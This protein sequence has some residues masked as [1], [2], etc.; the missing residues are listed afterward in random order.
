MAVSGLRGQ[1]PHHPVDPAKVGLPPRPFLYTLDQI[2]TILNVPLR[3]V[4][5][6]YVYY[7]GRSTG[8]RAIRLLEAKNIEPDE[9]AKPDWRV[10]ERELIRWM[11]VMGFKYYDRGVITR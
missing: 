10:A 11:K 1:N 4:K 5:E 8:R 6:K 9:S 7:E 3:T 2:S